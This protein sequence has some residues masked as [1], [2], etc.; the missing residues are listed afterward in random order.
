MRAFVEMGGAVHLMS[1]IGGAEHTLCGVAFDANASENADELGHQPTQRRTVTC[2][3]CAM[4]VDT[5]RG[6]R[7]GRVTPSNAP[8]GAG[9]GETK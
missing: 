7:V 2:L 9:G 3:E 4:V 1:P 8:A 5:C 6:V